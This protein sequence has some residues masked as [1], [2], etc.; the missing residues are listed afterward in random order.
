MKRKLIFSAL[1][2]AI[3][4]LNSTAAYGGEIIQGDADG[5][6]LLTS[7]DCTAIMQ[8]VY[9]SSYK[10]PVEDLT[11]DYMTVVDVNGDAVLTSADAASV[12]QKVLFD[13]FE[14]APV[15]YE[16]EIVLADNATT[17]NGLTESNGGVTLDNETNLVT[18]TNGG[19]YNVSGTLTNGQLVVN[20]D[21]DVEINLNGVSIANASGPAIYGLSGDIDI[22]A[23]KGTVNT[24]S[25]GT[26][27]EVDA[28][29]E[30]DACIFS[31]DSIKLKGTGELTIYGNYSNGVST[32]DSLTVQKLTL[33]INS[34]GNCLK[35][36]DSVIITSG[37]MDLTSTTGD[38]IRCTKGDLTVNGG[39]ATIKAED[40][41]LFAKA[42]NII[43][44]DGE[45][46]I[47]TDTQS[48]DTATY[49]YDGVHS[50]V[51]SV[52]LNGGSLTVTSY[53]DGVQAATEL[54]VGAAKVNITTTAEMSTSAGGAPG[55]QDSTDTGVS[56]KGLKSDATL[57]IGD[58]ADITVNSTDDS[59][60][61]NDTVT[62]N[63]G[64]M[65][66]SA[67]DDGVHADTTLTVNGGSINVTKSYEGL[68]AENIYINSGDIHILADD[69]S[70]N[71]AGGNDSSGN[72]GFGSESST[73][74]MEFNGGYVYCENTNNGDGI[75]SNGS[76]VVNG[77][78]I[79]INGPSSNDNAPVDYGDGSGSYLAYNGGTLV[80]VGSAGMAVKPS[81]SS[82]QA[83][84]LYY[85]S[86]SG[87][88]GGFGGSFGGGMGGGNTGSGTG[89]T[90][91][92][93]ISLTDSSS[94]LLLAFKP[95][96]NADSILICSDSIKTGESYTLSTGGT[97]SGTLND[98][99]Y[100][101][102]GTVSGSTAAAK[103]T[104]SGKVTVMSAAN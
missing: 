4:A 89:I 10:M 62:I 100:G 30:P 34:T 9:N 38:G 35:G 46:N 24:L 102:D 29:G 14:F 103:G 16:S 71:A 96:T 28:D 6:G 87:N 98:D 69:D 68:E 84:S 11:D 26:P 39:T 93:L 12:L 55:W 80:A 70:I 50:K 88:K 66:L 42:G 37:T 13:S 99:G 75:D 36:K 73:G 52:S 33:T 63:G 90:A 83:Y 79:V 67:G 97:Y 48:A 56:A 1:A 78:T 54:N 86:S 47:D 57:V 61:A 49:N 65:T 17:V 5:S 40:N 85:G 82:S 23:K 59:I 41:G 32:K 64:T 72:F 27:A 15:T 7:N 45:I 95:K 8:K 104:V 91:G 44:N 58:G 25:D 53:C 76:I 21:S 77:G 81:E 20:A 22:S 60:H 43:I 31:H 94:N 92:T 101:T 3:F 19:I 2:A 74:Y 18:I 51:G